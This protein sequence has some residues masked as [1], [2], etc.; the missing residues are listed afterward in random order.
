MAKLLIP[1][2][3]AAVLCAPAAGTALAQKSLYV[4]EAY[5]KVEPFNPKWS[6][7][8]NAPRHLFWPFRRHA[9]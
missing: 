1:L 8:A 5:P 4:P 6:K 7:P 2:I 9:R 3:A